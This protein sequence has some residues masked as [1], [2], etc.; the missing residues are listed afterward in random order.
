MEYIE[1]ILDYLEQNNGII[2]SQYCREENIPTVYLT[3]LVKKN[4]LTRVDRGIY[5]SKDGD[6]DVYYFFQHKFK[7]A[8]FS[9]ETALY[10][11]G[12]TDKIP[13]VIEVSVPYSYKFNNVPNNLEVYYVKKEIAEMGTTKAITNFGN[14]V[15]AYNIE[16]V[17]CDFI[18][19]K[20]DVD[21]EIYVKTIRD[22][23]VSKN[24][25]INKLFMY[26]ERM[27]ITEKVRNTMEIIY[28]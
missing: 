25:D 12:L 20:S 14:Q 13:H 7:K 10:L 1:K 23:A 22:Y 5:I 9:Y 8:I 15:K 18:Q 11:Q 17:V 27:G 6:Y 26:A 24:A 19:N 4:V 3:R 21:P 28:K 16:R 2:T